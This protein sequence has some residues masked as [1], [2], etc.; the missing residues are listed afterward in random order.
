MNPLFS[1][2]EEESCLSHPHFCHRILEERGKRCFC[3]VLGVIP[4]SI[5]VEHA[6]LKST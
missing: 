2:V 5:V 6:S 1:C 4:S 3:C